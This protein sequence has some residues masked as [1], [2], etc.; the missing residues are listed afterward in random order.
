MVVGDKSCQKRVGKS[1]GGEGGRE[2]C[3]KLSSHHKPGCWYLSG[4]N[5]AWHCNFFGIKLPPSLPSPS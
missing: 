2:A 4:S 5:W 3:E 1:V